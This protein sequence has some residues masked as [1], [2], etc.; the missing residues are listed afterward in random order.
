MPPV[1]IWI[2]FD[3]RESA[4]FAVCR[5][6]LRFHLNGPFPI[7]GLVLDDLIEKG[8]YTRPTEDRLGKTWDV[9]S[10]AYQ[11]TE[12]ANSRFLVP[13]LTG[14]GWGLFMDCD[15]LPRRDITTLFTKEA[16]SEYAVMCVKHRHEPKNTEKMDGQAQALYARKNWSSF[17]L[18]NCD[19]PSNRK[20]TVEMV[21]TLPGR[22]LHR[23]C[24]LEDHEIGDLGPEWNYLVGHT[25]ANVDPRVVHFTDGGP[26]F[27]A[28]RDVPYANEWTKAF[29]RWA[30]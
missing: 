24:W 10:G 17:M 7:C 14:T 12:F 16:K 30:A 8:L 23:F 21:N 6:Q 15:M 5:D 9:I 13:H 2:G 11:S 25:E 27:R 28:F 26:W 18:F 4:A 20:L 22:D 19:H 29:H 3:P 1:T